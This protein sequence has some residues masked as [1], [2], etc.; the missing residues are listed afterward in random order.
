MAP[1]TKD[2]CDWL[3]KGA[4]RSRSSSVPVNGSSYDEPQTI[5][6]VTVTIGKLSAFKLF[7]C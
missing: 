4:A 5:T 6:I 1:R 3:D 2:S 7:A